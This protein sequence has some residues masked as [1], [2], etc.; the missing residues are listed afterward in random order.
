MIQ[1]TWFDRL[2]TIALAMV[3]VGAVLAAQQMN[4]KPGL[5][6]ASS[7]S[8]AAEAAAQAATGYISI[9]AAAFEPHS[10]S[11]EYDNRGNS[12]STLSGGG[13][14]YAPV[15]LPHGA[16]VT[17]MIFVF[18][19]DEETEHAQVKM[20]CFNLTSGSLMGEI[21]SLNEGASSENTTV[22]T[23]PVIDNSEYSYYIELFLSSEDVYLYQVFIEFTYPT[24]FMPLVMRDH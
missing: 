11:V 4:L 22:F 9:S 15:Q 14:F 18:F 3:M 17:N 24:N 16:T 6:S 13:Y 21:T 19:D 23:D 1:K 20:Y 8:L 5:P 10:K 2:L 12:L 7:G